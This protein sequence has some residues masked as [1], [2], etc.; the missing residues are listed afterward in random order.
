MECSR[1]EDAI[2]HTILMVILSLPLGLLDKI[3]AR[4]RYVSILLLILST[5]AENPLLLIALQVYTDV[6]GFG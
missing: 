2:I 5:K 6:P 1:P 4:Y 3:C